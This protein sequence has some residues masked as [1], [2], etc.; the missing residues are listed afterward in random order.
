MGVRTFFDCTPAYVGRNPR[1]LK[2][3]AKKT[4]INIVSNTGYYGAHSNKFLPVFASTESAE[5][6]A[7]RWIREWEHGMQGTRIKPGFIKIGVD[8]G[9]LSEMHRKLVRAACFTH[10]ETG[11]T[12]AA[13]TGSAEG[14]F[15]QLE[16]LQEEG[17][18]PS[19]FIWVHAQAEKNTDLHVSPMDEIRI[20]SLKKE[21]RTADTT[22]THFA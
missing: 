22:I 7:A 17:V 3:I 5:Q 4:G 9:G 1:L 19:A 13:H 2:K 10:A 18:V 21:S 8:M 12:I 20:F 6:L 16:V 11:L 14:A 15:E